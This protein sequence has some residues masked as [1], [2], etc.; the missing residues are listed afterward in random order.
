MVEKRNFLEQFLPR[1][2]GQNGGR[3]AM[4]SENIISIFLASFHETTHI[5]THFVAK[6]LGEFVITQ[7]TERK[8]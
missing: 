1:S 4:A 8:F 3:G 5:R 7:K 6:V 2:M